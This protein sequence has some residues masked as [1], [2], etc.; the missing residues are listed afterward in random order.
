[1]LRVMDV[2]WVPELRMSVLSVSTLEKKG[3]DVVFQDR[4]VLIK[5][6]GYSSDKTTILG[7]RESN[8]YKIKG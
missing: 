1:M 7:V 8:L 3:F 6:R 4:Q 2:L 5:T